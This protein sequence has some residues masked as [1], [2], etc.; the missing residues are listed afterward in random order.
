MKTS[1]VLG[2]H[3]VLPGQNVRIWNGGVSLPR[4]IKSSIE[5]VRHGF[6]EMEDQRRTFGASLRVPNVPARM[7]SKCG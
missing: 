5:G 1:T 4:K 3:A 2:K 7:P 6:F